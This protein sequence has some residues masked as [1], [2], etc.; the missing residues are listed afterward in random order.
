MEQREPLAGAANAV[1]FPR[2]NV[3][4]DF[5]FRS[6][7]TAKDYPGTLAIWAAVYALLNC[8]GTLVITQGSIT[9]T[10]LNAMLKK[11]ERLFDD[12]CGGVFVGIRYTFGITTLTSP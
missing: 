11:I 1:I 2:G 8:Q 7:V 12:R 9:N 3:S 10:A 5:V 6:G 4:G